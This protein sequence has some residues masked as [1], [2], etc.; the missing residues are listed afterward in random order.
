VVR[1]RAG[2]PGAAEHGERLVEDGRPFTALHAE[3][4]L[5]VRIGHAEPERRQQPA[6]GQPVDR[7]QLLGQHDRIAPR[8]HQHAHAELQPRGAAR[9]E[10][11]RRHRVGRLAA[12]ALAEPQAVEVEAF[13]VVDERPEGAVV[14]IRAHAQ[15]VADADLHSS[16]SSSSGCRPSRR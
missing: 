1:Q 3:R 4:L 16:S 9:P 5:L 12:D 13:E 10:R 8:Q 14:E 7:R 2:R 15:A 11:D 6:A